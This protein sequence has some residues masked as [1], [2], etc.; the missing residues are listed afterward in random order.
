MK[1]IGSMVVL[2]FCL[3]FVSLQMA[4]AREENSAL[5]YDE[6]ERTVGEIAEYESF[7][8]DLT[9]LTEVYQLHYL[10]MDLI[11]GRT[12][13]K[14]LEIDELY[15][16]ENLRTWIL[17]CRNIEG[18]EMFLKLFILGNRIVTTQLSDTNFFSTTQ[19][20]DAECL[21]G[22]QVEDVQ[23]EYLIELPLYRFQIRYLLTKSGEE[24]VIPYLPGEMERYNSL[25]DGKL[26]TLDTFI[27]TMYNCY[28]ENEF[29][30]DRN[31]HGESD[32][33]LVPNRKYILNFKSVSEIRRFQRIMIFVPTILITLAAVGCIRGIV[34]F[35]V[36]RK[37]VKKFTNIEV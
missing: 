30:I 11:Q 33:T 22:L 26:Y 37:S 31:I 20:F 19:K 16:N 21:G 13:E 23:Q 3:V 8:Y 25:K 14:L 18:Q 27:S 36:R 32:E 35:V 34:L 2:M 6:I 29:I 9:E 4:Y 12:M 28:D 1:K 24:Y 5:L 15:G 17:P 7:S 10:I